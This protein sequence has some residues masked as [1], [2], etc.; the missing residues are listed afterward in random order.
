MTY[1]PLASTTD[2]N[3]SPFNALAVSI[4]AGELT[5]TLN[6]ASQAIEDFCDRRLAP[7]TGLTET[8]RQFGVKNDLPGD[9]MVGDR[10]AMINLDRMRALGQF[11]QAR[12]IF[13]REFPPLWEDQWTGAVSNISLIYPFGGSLA[14]IPASSYEFDPNRGYVRFNIGVFC[15]PGTSASVTYSGGY[16][17]VP[18]ALN[19]AC[20][21]EAARLL[22]IE[23][24]PS[25]AD[26]QRGKDLREER[27]ELV[28]AY[29][30]GGRP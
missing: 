20:L 15:P 17:T 18:Y 3:N 14:T 19:Q 22:M 12:H 6:R 11:S 8:H 28:M 10:D 13:L 25:D 1:T 9:T 27:D 24:M 5:N 16:S 21:L 30:R 7:F 2:F 29:E 4:S 26:M 23:L